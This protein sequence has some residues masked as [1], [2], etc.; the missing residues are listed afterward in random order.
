MKRT[1]RHN[2]FAKAITGKCM[3]ETVVGCSKVDASSRVFAKTAK[4]NMILA[5]EELT[6]YI[7]TLEL[8]RKKL[9]KLIELTMTLIQRTQEMTINNKRAVHGITIERK[10]EGIQAKE[11]A[12]PVKEYRPS[13]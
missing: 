9:D 3:R 10:R 11:N 7:V 12:R 4:D 1:P 8:D 5:A 13:K 2:F 6:A